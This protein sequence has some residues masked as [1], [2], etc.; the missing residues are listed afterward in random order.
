VVTKDIPA[1]C[2]AAGNPCRVIRKITEADR[3]TYC[4]HIPVDQDALEHMRR[5]WA[6]SNDSIKYPSAPEK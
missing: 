1:W 4:H 2:V 3:E 6:E 5:M